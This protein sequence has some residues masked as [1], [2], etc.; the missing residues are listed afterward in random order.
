MSLIREC[1]GQGR[2][3]KLNLNI[4]G[5]KDVGNKIVKITEWGEGTLEIKL[6]KLGGGGGE[7]RR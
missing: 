6:L 2:E 1:E 5:K 4:C 3:E 7:G